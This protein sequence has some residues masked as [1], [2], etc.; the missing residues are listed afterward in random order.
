MP[1]LH[2][3]LFKKIFF[4][5]LQ[6]FKPM[7]SSSVPPFELISIV[8]CGGGGGASA[9]GQGSGAAGPWLGGRDAVV[10]MVS[11]LLI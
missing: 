1:L 2:H 11:A 8:E 3:H 4:L 9:L 10:V 6:T 5:G 7:S